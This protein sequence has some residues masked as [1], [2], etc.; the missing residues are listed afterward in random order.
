[1]G[2]LWCA[3]AGLSGVLVWDSG[4][5]YQQVQS[6][7]A[8]TS[9]VSLPTVSPPCTVNSFKV[10][11]TLVKNGYVSYALAVIYVVLTA[12]KSCYLC[13]RISYLH[14]SV[15]KWQYVTNV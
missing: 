4:A 10:S 8:T 12:R 3:T 9:S 2:L 7:A 14:A 1:M 13:P 6:Q 11:S 15:E 5:H